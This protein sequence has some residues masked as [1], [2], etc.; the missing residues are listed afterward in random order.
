[1]DRDKK[2]MSKSISIWVNFMLN[3]RRFCYICLCIPPFCKIPTHNILFSPF[4]ADLVPS[5]ITSPIFGSVRWL[6]SSADTCTA[7]TGGTRPG[8]AGFCPCAL[9]SAASLSAVEIGIRRS[10][11]SFGATASLLTRDCFPACFP[12]KFSSKL[13]SGR[14]V[15][16]TNGSAFLLSVVA[17][18]D[19]DWLQGLSKWIALTQLVQLPYCS[20]RLRRLDGQKQRIS[21]GFTRN[22]IQSREDPLFD[23]YE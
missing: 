22:W 5:S 9:I 16:A 17:L 8:L 3:A 14:D 18:F 21:G 23:S 10:I 1:M 20:C 6:L 4:I 11:N 13:R 2:S 12:R 7:P 19:F 15:P